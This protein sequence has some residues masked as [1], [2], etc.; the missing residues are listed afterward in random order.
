MA[1]LTRQFHRRLTREQYRAYRRQQVQR[2]RAS[3]RQLDRIHQHLPKQ[4]HTI[5]DPLESAFS[6]P[7]HRRFLVLG[8]VAI[9]TLGGRTI[10]NL[11]RCLGA[12]TPGH[13]SSYHRVFSHR[14]WSS[15]KLA[16]QFAHTVLA[17]FL[18]QGPIELAGDDTVTEHPGPHVYGKGCHRDPVRST[19]AYTAYR[20]GHKWVALTVLVKVPWATRRWA[21]PLLIA[22][23]QTPEANRAQ[24][25]RHKTPSQLMRQI[26]R[27]L[28]RWFPERKFVITG[29][30]NYATHE[31]AELTTRYPGRLT[32]VSKFYPTANLT[33]P[34]PPS[35]GRRR[36]RGRPRVKGSKLPNPA[37]VVQGTS[38]RQPLEVSWY[39]G[40]R[41]RVEVV[42]GKGCW[43]ESGGKLV[44]VLWVFV[45]DRSGTHREEY[46]FTTDPTM[47]PKMVIETYTGRW[48]I[49]T[50]FQ[51][52]RSYLGL[53]TTRGWSRNT[54]LRVGPCLF[55][56]YTVVALLYSELPA[57]YTRVHVVDWPGKR[58][59]TFSDAITA[60][61]RWLWV[62]WV[63]AIPGYREA[64]SKLSSPFRQILLH[65]LAPAA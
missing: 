58:D 19:H 43:Y 24:K 38:T 61:R 32:L 34:K 60:V 53:E 30:G 40:G 46:F 22:L 57:R 20:W 55:G 5:L 65:G 42:T 47:S 2:A 59:V 13:S 18:P 14:R 4:V 52:V 33:S 17:Q 26:L 62:E 15:W 10:A 7:T 48:N 51:E 9:L 41:R 1:S 25:R 21:L 35:T 11:L 23:Y 44:P 12:L 64:F 63:F 36:S 29:D 27:V 49:E 28:L 37:A 39:G 56:L 45:H 16:R 50:M 31:L 6:R 54:V 3:R 8:V